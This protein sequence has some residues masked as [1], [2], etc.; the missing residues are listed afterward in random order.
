MHNL[1]PKRTKKK[2]NA[3]TKLVVLRF[4]VFLVITFNRKSQQNWISFAT[5]T[6]ARIIEYDWIQLISVWLKWQLDRWAKRVAKDGKKETAS[7]L[8]IT[9]FIH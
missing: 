7:W 9:I 5:N 2:K 8:T 1:T 3:V 6:F 4:S